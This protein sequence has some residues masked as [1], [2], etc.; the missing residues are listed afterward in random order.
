MTDDMIKE[1]REIGCKIT[2]QAADKI[3]RLNAENEDWRQEVDDLLRQIQN[4]RYE[5]AQLQAALAGSS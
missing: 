5:I 3:E 1:L 2:D 4:L